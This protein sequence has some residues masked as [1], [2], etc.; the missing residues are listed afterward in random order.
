MFVIS[1]GRPL[2]NALG[3]YLVPA[4]RTVERELPDQG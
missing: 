4:I 3:A 2:A 1:G